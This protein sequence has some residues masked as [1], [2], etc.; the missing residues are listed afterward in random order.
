ML[1]SHLN[2]SQVG[3][4]GEQL[5]RYKLMRWG[6]EA[7]MVEQGNDYDIVVLGEMP[8]RIQ[9]KSTKEP[10]PGRAQSYK[11]ST[12]KGSTCT[13]KYT[14]EMVDCFAFVALDIE[15]ILFTPPV[16]TKSKR[17]YIDKFIVGDD[18][19]SWSDIV[20]TIWQL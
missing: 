8:I 3:T 18:Y 14:K 16:L 4:V 15:K 2:A 6:Y 10:D 13:S 7:I 1:N 20:D 9:V 17:I 5:V 19:T 12:C 11:F